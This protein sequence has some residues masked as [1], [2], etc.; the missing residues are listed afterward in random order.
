MT[1]TKPTTHRNSPEEIQAMDI[2]VLRGILDSSP[3]LSVI[4][5]VEDAPHTDSDSAVVLHEPIYFHSQE[6]SD[7][8]TSHVKPQVNVSMIIPEFGVPVKMEFFEYTKVEVYEGVSHV[9]ASYIKALLQARQHMPEMVVNWSMLNV[10]HVNSPIVH[11]K[12]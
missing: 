8:N 3:S 9:G 4:G 7:Q 11:T 2:V 10:K 6:R 5:W 12:P 1:P